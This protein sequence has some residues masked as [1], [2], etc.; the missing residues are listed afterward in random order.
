LLQLMSLALGVPLCGQHVFRRSVV[1]LISLED[2][3]HELQRRIEAVLQHFGIARAELTGWLFCATPKGKLAELHGRHRRIGSLDQQIR[4]AIQ[5]RNPDIVALDPFVKLHSLNENDSGD[6]NFVCEL[7]VKIAVET[8]IAVDIPHHVHKGSITPGDADAGRG[9][10][11]IR[12][13]GRLTYTLAPMSEE[14]AK[15][16]GI[17]DGER[18][19]FVRLDSAKVNIAPRGGK[20][21]WFQLI[22]VPIGNGT[23]DYPNGDAIQVA[24]PW[25]PPDVWD[26]VDKTTINAILDDIDA[27]LPDGERYSDAAAAKER[28]A[29]RAVQRRVPTKTEAQAREI[30]R[31][32]VKNGVLEP[33]D[34][35]SEVARKTFSGLHVNAV[36]RP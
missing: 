25:L 10:S 32:W 26:G 1:L 22:S 5:R 15:A 4:A 8:K 3:R 11:G 21:A 33:T 2:D 6:M 27:G 35:R 23:A 20:A 31:Q 34:Y 19:N 36:R 28:A 29:W 9:S 24:K 12:D 17:E 7:L 18:F 13:A 14:E 30:I 16:F